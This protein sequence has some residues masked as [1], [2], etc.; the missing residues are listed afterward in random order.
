MPKLYNWCGIGSI[1]GTF[2][3]AGMMSLT[4]LLVVSGAMAVVVTVSAPLAMVML[5]LELTIHDLS[6][7]AMLSIIANFSFVL[8]SFFIRSSTFG[9]R[10]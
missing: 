5:V 10:N 3:M 9:A 8:W 1:T 6:L 2:G 4:M 7:A